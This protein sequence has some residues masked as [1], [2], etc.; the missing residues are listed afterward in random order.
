MKRKLVILS[1]ILALVALPLTSA[2]AAPAPAGPIT[3]TMVGAWAPG[4]SAAADVAM[5]FKDQVNQRSEGRLI[6]EY[7]GS[8]EVV[9]TFDQPEALVKGVFDVWYGAPN[10]W[11]GVIPAG[12]ILELSPFAPPD[13][14][15]GSEV[16][17]YMVEIY[18]EKGVRYLGHYTGAPDK[19]NHFLHTL[20]KVTNI[21]DFAGMKIRVPPLTRQFVEAIGAEPVT[22]PPGE[23]YIALE[24]GV[25]DGLSWPY[26]DG[27][28]EMG[29]AEIAKYT[30]GYPLYRDGTGINMNLNVWNNLPKDLQAV[31]TD[32][33]VETQSWATGWVDANDTSQLSRMQAAGMEVIKFSA[34]EGARYTKLSEDALWTYFYGKVSSERYT[35]LRQ[36]L[37]Y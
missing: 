7:K 5:H 30:I 8:K 12:H 28:V 14:G 16:Y 37:G 27:F 34:A 15:P 26:W 17:D 31:L 11:A 1:L 22:L 9:P 13:K 4:I 25:V 18:A 6:I 20:K 2:C 36:L 3:L 23:V 21:A 35:K 33:V 24:R 10:Y 19:G 32:A 29:W